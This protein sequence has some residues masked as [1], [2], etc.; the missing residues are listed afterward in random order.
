[1]KSVVN[2]ASA[3]GKIILI[4][5]FIIYLS[6]LFYL[7]FFSHLYGRE[8]FHRSINLIPFRTIYQY[9]TTSYN[10]KIV[11]INML[12]NIAAFG[13]MGFLLPMVSKKFAGLWGTLL[14]AAGISLMI[15]ITQYAFGIGAADIDDLFLNLAGG[16]LGY[17]IY[18]LVGMVYE[19][20]MRLS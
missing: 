13:P 8:Y 15:E 18:K 7:T 6:Y 4:I 12:G 9:M 14:F 10:N 1:M 20:L 17:G 19:K 16:L 5:L 11:V 2:K 3:L